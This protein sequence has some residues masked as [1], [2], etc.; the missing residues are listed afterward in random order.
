MIKK[1]VTMILLS[2][3]FSLNLFSVNAQGANP[4]GIPAWKRQKK[5]P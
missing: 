1:T 2:T 3:L 5:L 4:K